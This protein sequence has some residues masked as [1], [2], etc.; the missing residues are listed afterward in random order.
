M[1]EA[2]NIKR[3]KINFKLWLKCLSRVPRVDK[4]Q[5]QTLDAVSRWLIASRAIALTMTLFSCML[6]GI[7]SW[8]DG[9]FNAALFALLTFGLIFSHATNNL[10]NDYVDHVKGVDKDNYFRTQYGPQPLEH[11]LLTKDELKRYIVFT[12]GA[13]IL[14]GI[15]LVIFRGPV[16]LSLFLLGCFFVLFYTYPLKYIGLGEPA[17]MLVWGP[18]MIA[19]GY[20]VI[21]AR[22]DW[23]VVIASI[24]Y[25]LGVTT[26]LFG[27]HIDKLDADKKKSIRTLPVLLGERHAKNAA[28]LMSI[29]QYLLVFYL[30][31]IRFFSSVMFV[32]LFALIVFRFFVF[33]YRSPKPEKMPEQFIAEIWP[34]WYVAF[35][36]YHNRRFGMFFIL[37]L[38]IDAVIKHI[39]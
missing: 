25:A 13:A 33:V 1:E 6:A 18:L 31:A 9:L 30:V 15:A 21:T 23:N 8:R 36:F 12:G 32:V 7:L 39:R 28:I 34:A 10:L 29:A 35:A 16:V 20:Y 11:G 3:R 17:V 38:F 2:I 5:W 37:G 4:E 14:I 26:V 27:K 24:P 19:G 22:W